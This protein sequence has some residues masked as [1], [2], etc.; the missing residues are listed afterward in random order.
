M[1]FISVMAKLNFQQHSSS[2]TWSFRNPSNILCWYTFFNFFS[3]IKTVVLLIIFVETL[4]IFWNYFMNTKWK[5]TAVICNTFFCNAVH[6][7]TVTFE[8]IL[9]TE[10]QTCINTTTHTK[11]PTTMTPLLTFIIFSQ[12]KVSHRFWNNI[13]ANKWWQNL[14]QLLTRKANPI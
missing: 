12:K 14:Q 6:V 4:Y 3:L 10:F 7:F 8:Q 11:K 9:I 2:F 5:R 13:R 1:L